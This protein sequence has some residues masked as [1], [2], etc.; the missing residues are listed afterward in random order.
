[1]GGG[2][3]ARTLCWHW[4]QRRPERGAG[5]VVDY[6]PGSTLL[7]AAWLE[8]VWV[9][10]CPAASVHSLTPARPILV[11]L[12]WLLFFCTPRA[13]FLSRGFRLPTAVANDSG[14]STCIPNATLRNK[15][16]K[17]FFFSL[18]HQ[19]LIVLSCPLLLAKSHPCTPT[20]WTRDW[21]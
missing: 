13:S 6:L 18:K 19:G 20:P 1:M 14:N 12:H 2:W 21:N 11:V 5:K 15:R 7:E 16:D 8:R 9:Q 17:C 10:L 4:H 3:L